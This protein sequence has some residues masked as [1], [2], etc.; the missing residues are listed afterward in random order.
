[1]DSRDIVMDGAL[2]SFARRIEAAAILSAIETAQ[3]AGVD[4]ELCEYD[5]PAELTPASRTLAEFTDIV[6]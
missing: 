3:E 4:P 2:E 5:P 6:G 1:M